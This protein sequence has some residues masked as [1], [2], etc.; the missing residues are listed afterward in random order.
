MMNNPLRY[1]DPSGQYC[2]TGDDPLQN[3]SQCGRA[4][5]YYAPPL[6]ADARRLLEFAK[7]NDVTVENVVIAGLAGEAAGWSTNKHA[8]AVLPSTWGNRYQYYVLHSCGGYASVNCRL[9]F[10]MEY[11]E[12]LGRLVNNN[13]NAPISK[14]QLIT[15]KGQFD[16]ANWKAGKQLYDAILHPPTSYDPDND[17]ADRNV[18]FDVAIL[19]T[20][21]VSNPSIGRGYDQ[22][23]YATPVVYE[24]VAS[25]SVILSYCQFEWETRKVHLAGCY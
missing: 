12:S 8:M 13:W 10:L 1:T 19:P 6:S 2:W 18:G 23:M 24:G 15:G 3:S 5:V 9:N 25:Y 17:P 20:S 4:N 22:F 11:S 14:V 7:K 16:D 21:T